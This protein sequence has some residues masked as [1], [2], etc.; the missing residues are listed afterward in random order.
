[1]KRL[2]ESGPNALVQIQEPVNKFPDFVRYMVQRLRALCPTMEKVK[3]AQ[4]L[5]RAG[6]HMG[7]TTVGRILKEG[8]VPEPSPAA[9]SEVS[10]VVTAKRANHVW[11]VDLTTV[12]TGAGFWCSWLP[13]ALP[14]SWPFSWW[15]AV[16]IDHY[17]RRVMGFTL[18]FQEP[19][20]QAV[21][22]FLGRAQ[23]TN[24]ARPKYLICDKGPQFWC[25]GFKSWCQ[26]TDVRPRFGA[27]G[28]HGSIAV[29]ERAI[30]TMKQLL[31][32]L[33]LIPLRRDAFRHELAAS[34][35]WYNEHRPHMTLAGRTPNEVYF[36][37]SPAHRS[38]RWEPRPDWP[39]RAPCS[40]PRT[41]VKGNPGVRLRLDV[42]YHAGRKDLPIL[43]LNRAA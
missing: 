38:P 8:A 37:R 11:H 39:R 31:R 15:V 16:I 9:G 6:L 5:A 20:S 14:Q 13:F 2:D 40:N 34:F 10:R 4:T 43:Q 12:P 18:F 17:S 29:I 30:L 24:R 25:H 41:L 36:Q 1:M 32:G 7:P 33:P 3:I 21:R 28:R 27:I 35:V 23:A 22:A 42:D 19:T 26:R